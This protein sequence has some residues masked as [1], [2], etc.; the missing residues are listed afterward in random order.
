MVVDL[1]DKVRI[2]LWWVTGMAAS[3]LCCAVLFVILGNHVKDLNKDL[4]DN[5][6]SIA[7]IEKEQM[8]ISE[9]IGQ[10]SGTMLQLSNAGK[11]QK[12]K[13][14]VQVKEIE[15]KTETVSEIEYDGALYATTRKEPM[16]ILIDDDTE[17]KKVNKKQKKKKEIGG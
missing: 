17:E 11:L 8:K 4:S 6:A 5:S 1:S 7:A 10:L 13:V 9:A 3:V 15:K 14:V 16:V 2:M 12:E